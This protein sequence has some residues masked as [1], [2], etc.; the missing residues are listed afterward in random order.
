MPTPGPTGTT[1]RIAPGEIRQGQGSAGGVVTRGLTKQWRPRAVGRISPGAGR[2]LL[3]RV[4]EARGMIGDRDAFL[5]PSMTSLHD[6]SLLPGLDLAARRILGAARG[7]ERVVIYGDYDVDGISASAI[8]YHA[9]RHVAPEARVSTYVPHRVEEGYGLNAEAIAK[10]AGEGARVIV[11]VDCGVTATGP[12]EIAGSL[13]VDLII[14]DHH[15]TPERAEDFPRAY[16]IVHPRLPGTAPAYPFGDLSGSAVAFKLAWRLATLAAG[17]ERVGASTRG[18][19]LDLLALASLGVIADVVP[20]RGENRVIA[21]HGLARLKST[22]CAGLDA[23]IEASG[24]SGSRISAEDVGFRLAPRL[25]ACGRLG[26]AREAMELL[27]T[28][29]G[30]RAKALAEELTRLNE[31]RRVMERRIFEQACELAESGGMASPDHPAIVLAHPEWHQGV[32]GIVC[33]RLVERYARPVILMQ[34]HGEACHGSGRSVEGVSLVEALRGCAGRLLAFGGHEMAAG[35]KVARAEMDAFREAFVERCR[36]SLG[37]RELVAT[38]AYDLEVDLAELGAGAVR[39]LSAMAPFGRDN[40]AVVVRV[41]G[42][43]V[44]G[45]PQRMGAGGRHLAMHVSRERGGPAWRCVAWNWGERVRDIPPGATLDL[46]ATPEVSGW[47]GGVE[48]VVRD[49]AIA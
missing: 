47:S 40:P 8:L 9:I 32:V 27:T 21:R 20:L 43:R 3:D 46:L 24:L 30:E 4:L 29:R 2:T 15:A 36:E 1:Q 44:A 34:D 11:T 17:T 7:G 37:G 48:L 10:L 38:E 33:S 5:D 28:A 49:V 41:I 26:H 14:T 16:A 45:E 31:E 13:G 19:L 39:G 22:S 18:V 25:N 23:I 12:A 42:V 35:L 6:P